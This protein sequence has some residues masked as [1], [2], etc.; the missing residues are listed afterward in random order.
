MHRPLTF[1]GRDNSAGAC[2]ACTVAPAPHSQGRFSL[3][4]GVGARWNG[5]GPGVTVPVPD[6]IPNPR[7]PSP[8][9]WSPLR[10]TGA[11]VAE[12]ARR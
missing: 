5:A 7:V 10:R 3:V 1:P 2:S 6:P 12:M 8:P 11:S 9:R 4:P